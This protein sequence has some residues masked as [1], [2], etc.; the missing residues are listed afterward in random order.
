MKKQI[1][2]LIIL[3]FAGC[4][5]DSNIDSRPEIQAINTNQENEWIRWTEP[6]GFYSIEVPKDWIFKKHGFNICGKQYVYSFYGPNNIDEITISAS[7]NLEYLPEQ[8]SSFV[9][10][11]AFPDH[12]PTTE[13]HK[14]Y[15]EKWDGWRQNYEQGNNF[16]YAIAARNNDTVVLLTIMGQEKEQLSLDST[17][18]RI[19]ESLKVGDGV[20]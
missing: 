19:I 2:I 13:L 5:K 7:Y 8:T 11:E 1:C 18:N 3:L 15:G 12:K 4:S 10:T 14:A 6:D 20:K 17:Y 9:L 16:W